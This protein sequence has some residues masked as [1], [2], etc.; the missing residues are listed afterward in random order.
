MKAKQVLR[1]FFWHTAILVVAP[2]VLLT[3]VLAYGLHRPIP[4]F[5]YCF[6]VYLIFPNRFRAHAA[7]VPEDA[8][9]WGLLVLFYLALA[10][11]SS[12]VHALIMSRKMVG[13]DGQASR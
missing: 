13:R 1:L 5:F 3:G 2:Q 9:A 12:S 8:M 11:V 4:F 6:P 7:I 10:L